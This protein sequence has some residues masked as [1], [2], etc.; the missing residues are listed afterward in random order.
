MK[1][2]PTGTKR[3]LLQTHI[4]LEAYDRLQALARC[5]EERPGAI[6]SR[7]IIQSRAHKDTVAPVAKFVNGNLEKKRGCDE[8]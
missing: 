8:V 3:R 5:L 1:Y 4:T 2:F 7:L 6:L